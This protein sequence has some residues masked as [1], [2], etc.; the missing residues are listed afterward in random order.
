MP[1]SIPPYVEL[2]NT[3]IHHDLGTPLYRET[4]T[5][6]YWVRDTG[7]FET[8]AASDDDRR[9]D[10]LMANTNHY[11][12]IDQRYPMAIDSDGMAECVETRRDYER[13]S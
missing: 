3:I 12:H 1:N 4:G 10:I 2:S 5:V 9:W 8:V 13:N 11:A 6:T 7:T